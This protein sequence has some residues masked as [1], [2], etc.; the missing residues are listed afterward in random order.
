MHIEDIEEGE[1][2]VLEVFADEKLNCFDLPAY[3]PDFSSI[4]KYYEFDIHQGYGECYLNQ[5]KFLEPGNYTVTIDYPGTNLYY[6]QKVSTTFEVNVMENDPNLEINVDDI[7][8]GEQV[9]ASITAHKKLNGTVYVKLDGYTSEYPVMMKDGHAQFSFSDTL[10]EGN[11]TASVRYDGDD[12]FNADENSTTF[13]VK[14]FTPTMYAYAKDIGTGESLI[15]NLQTSFKEP[16]KVKVQLSKDN[17]IITINEVQV[18]NTQT[19]QMHEK[20]DAGTYDVKV[21]FEGN[22]THHSAEATTSFNVNQ[23]APVDPNLRVKVN[24]ITKGEKAVAVISANNSLNGKVELKLN[25]FDAVY[26]VHVFSGSATFTIDEDL[27]PGDYRATV[28]YAGDDTF[29]QAENSTTFKVNKKVQADPNLSIKVNDIY[30]DD[31]AVA[32]ISTNNTLNGEA[33]VYLNNSNAVYPVSIVDGSGSVT[34][35]EDLAV[36]EYLVTV[37]FAGDDTF[38]EANNSTTFKVNKKEPN[39]V[40]PNLSIKVKNITEGDKAIVDISA[41]RTFT[42]KVQ[43][44]LNDSRTVYNVIVLAGK[45]RIMID[46]DLAHGEYLATVSFAG[47]DKF[48]ASTESVAF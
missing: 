23:K 37:N 46:R 7:N 22:K 18:T 19:I 12:R 20:M 9:T 48:K 42:G 10:E 33:K 32:V 35:D 41:N 47:D 38:K 1:V 16:A 36:G 5:E 26:P 8:V 27:A 4:F 30:E 6:P 17:E 44:K 15:I 25:G 13:E 29:K 28:S 14:K 40:D 3:C 39:L 21:V 24:D 34:I 2:P 11:Y 45:G 31:K 43:V